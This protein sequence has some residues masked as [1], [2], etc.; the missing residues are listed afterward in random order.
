MG[1]LCSSFCPDAAMASSRPIPDAHSIW[2][3]VGHVNACEGAILRRIRGEALEREGSD[4][5]P[6][7]QDAS[8]RAWQD[9]VEIL[10]RQHHELTEAIAAMPE[11]RLREPVPGKGL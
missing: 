9:T 3:L 8:Q 7:I 5:F 6:E 2:K 1:Q 10:T 11:S 4:N